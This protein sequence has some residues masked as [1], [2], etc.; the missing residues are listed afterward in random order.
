MM[1]MPK[2]TECTVSDCAY[3]NNQVCKTI[4]ITVGDS[5]GKQKCDTFFQS[6][7][8]GGI[9]DITAGVGACKISDCSFNK[10]LECSAEKIRVGFE[11][12]EAD[13]L[14]FEKR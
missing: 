14:T 10:E 6:A 4:A 13:C 2:V 9:Q 5:S 11:D 3:N 1:D 8:H 7:V 12:G